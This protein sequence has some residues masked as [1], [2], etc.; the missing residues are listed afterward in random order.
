MSQHL[1]SMDKSPKSTASPVLKTSHLKLSVGSLTTKTQISTKCSSGKISVILKAK[2]TKKRKH[3]SI[4]LPEMLKVQ[5][6]FHRTCPS[7]LIVRLET[8]I[9]PFLHPCRHC[10]SQ[11]QELGREQ[12]LPPRK[13]PSMQLV[14]LVALSVLLNSSLEDKVRVTPA[15]Q[16]LII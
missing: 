5:V 4:L 16:V 7:C 2:Q 3:N 6:F 9:F 15:D 10:L 8:I 11:D 14:Q 1:S 12:I 13:R